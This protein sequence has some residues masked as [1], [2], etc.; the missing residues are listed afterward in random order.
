MKHRY[1]TRLFL[2][3]LIGAC[4]LLSLLHVAEVI[5]GDATPGGYG[6]SQTL[7][8]SSALADVH[9]AHPMKVSFAAEI[10]LEPMHI[11]NRV[12]IDDGVSIVPKEAK[13]IANGYTVYLPVILRR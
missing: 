8:S 10:T 2:S 6:A 12:Y 1:S 4:F 9:A 7:M 13:T 5:L 3:T 11:I